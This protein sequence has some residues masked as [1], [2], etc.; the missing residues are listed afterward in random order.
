MDS[1]LDRSTIVGY[2]N[3]SFFRERRTGRLTI[4]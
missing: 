4:D 2:C 3:S 1:R